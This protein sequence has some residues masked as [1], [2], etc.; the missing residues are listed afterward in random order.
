VG[1]APLCIKARSK[2]FR[3]RLTDQHRAGV[4][5]A[6]PDPSSSALGG[7]R[8]DAPQFLSREYPPMLRKA[9]SG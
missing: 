5:I 8:E 9:M 2:G 3:S 6:G 4:R 7:A 1:S